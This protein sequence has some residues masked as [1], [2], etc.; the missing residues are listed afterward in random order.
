VIL[1]DTD[2]SD[3]DDDNAAERVQVTRTLPDVTNAVWKSP[4]TYVELFVEN[5]GPYKCLVDSGVSGGEMP[6]AKHTVVQDFISPAQP[7]QLQ[8][9]EVFIYVLQDILPMINTELCA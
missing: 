4:L 5:Q 6:V 8:I 9:S 3:D 7:M 1:D 2:V